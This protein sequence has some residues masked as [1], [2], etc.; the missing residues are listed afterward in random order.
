MRNIDRGTPGDGS[1]LSASRSLAQKEVSKKK[2][3]YYENAFAQREPN[4]NPR[5]R[6]GRESIVMADVRTNVIVQDEYMFI[7]DLS[8]TL[9]SRYARPDSSIC[10][11]ITHSAC[12]LFGGSFEPAYT[13]TITALPSLVQPTTN[14]RNAA[15]IQKSMED[16]LG[17]PPQRGL[18]R[19]VAVAEENLATNGRTVL[20]EIEELQRGTQEELYS[21][22]LKNGEESRPSGSRTLPSRS[23]SDTK[24]RASMRSLRNLKT[25]KGMDKL[26][27]QVETPTL[28]GIMETAG[29]GSIPAQISPSWKDKEMTIESDAERTNRYG[30]VM[31]ETPGEK[32]ALDRRAEKA[33][34]LGKRRSFIAAVF[35]K[36]G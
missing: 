35:G 9:S 10:V 5:E 32:S 29:S 19:F 24:K 34:K 12:L 36:A 14:K 3:Q 2:S 18:I 21:T 13:M 26:E 16:V 30:I 27:V 4:T 7:T 17:V 6:I 20:G 22:G 11:S 23:G 33:Q 28:S 8:Y 1:L 25:G 31:P 15:L